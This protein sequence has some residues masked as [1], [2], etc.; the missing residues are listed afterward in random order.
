MIIAL[1]LPNGMM[2]GSIALN[3]CFYQRVPQQQPPA[4]I[5]GGYGLTH[6]IDPEVSQAIVDGTWV[7]YDQIDPASER[8]GGA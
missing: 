6:G 7:E 4:H 5:Y 2:L 3:G 8:P 1:K